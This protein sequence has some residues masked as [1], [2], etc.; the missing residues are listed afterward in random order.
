[1]HHLLAFRSRDAAIGQRQFDVLVYRQVADQ[2]KCLENEPDLAIPD[3]GP[4]AQFDALYGLAVE[5]IAPVAGRI[6]QA[7]DRQQR[8]FSPRR[9]SRCTPASACVSISSVMKT[10][11]TPS[12]RMIASPNLLSCGCISLVEYGPP[13]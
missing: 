9:I 11:V 7:Q 13:A 4:L 3:A 8:R 10:F 1:M 2:I 6:Q 5:L 12:S